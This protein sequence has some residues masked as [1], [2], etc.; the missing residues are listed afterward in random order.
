MINTEASMMP[1]S[2]E[3]DSRLATSKSHDNHY[4][5]MLVIFGTMPIIYWVIKNPAYGTSSHPDLPVELNFLISCWGKR[6]HGEKI[7]DRTALPCMVC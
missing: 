1:D 6:Y 3:Y 7:K 5:D 4:I 2:K